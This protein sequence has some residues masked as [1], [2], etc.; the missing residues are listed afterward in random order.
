[1]GLVGGTVQPCMGPQWLFVALL[2]YVFMS[3][4]TGARAYSLVHTNAEQQKVTTIDTW[5]VCCCCIVVV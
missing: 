4:L 5:Y 1:M 3:Q 2:F